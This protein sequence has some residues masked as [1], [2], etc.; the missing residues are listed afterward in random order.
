M[1]TFEVV[2]LAQLSS[3]RIRKYYNH[4]AKIQKMI[5]NYR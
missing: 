1:K 4:L 5:D 2:H 3:R